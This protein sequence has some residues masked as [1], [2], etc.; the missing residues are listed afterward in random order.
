MDPLLSQFELFQGISADDLLAMQ[1]SIQYAS[2]KR[3]G[4]FKFVQSQNLYVY[5]LV[6]GLMKS[7][8]TNESGQEL[9]KVLIKPGMFVGD[10]PLLERLERENS[11]ATAVENSVIA[12]LD[13]NRVRQWLLKYEEF[14]IKLKQQIADRLHHLED[15]LL[16]VIYKPA[17]K[18]VVDFLISFT[19]N[20]GA[21]DDGGW[22]VKNFLTNTEIAQF[23][24]TSRQTVSQV[25]ND[26]RYKKLLD[27]DQKFL[28]IPNNSQLLSSSEHVT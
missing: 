22:T 17:E 8:I 25:L 10:V 6:E 15:R 9:I 28:R 19:M 20:F 7:I 1:Q 16:A 5:F 2:V 3:N 13:I 18:R 4:I 12:L 21:H 14:R 24:A 11:Y 26:L 27:Y 23:S